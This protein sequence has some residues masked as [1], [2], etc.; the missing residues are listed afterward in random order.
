MEHVHCPGITEFDFC[1]VTF[2][3]KYSFIIAGKFMKQLNGLLVK[4]C[5]STTFTIF[6]IPGGQKVYLQMYGKLEVMRLVLLSYILSCMSSMIHIN[7]HTVVHDV[8]VCLVQ[9]SYW[10]VYM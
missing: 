7:V 10:C 5:W 4:T 2:N 1:L 8:L 9:V 6:V 3:V